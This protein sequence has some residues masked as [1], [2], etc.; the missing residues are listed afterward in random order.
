MATPELLEAADVLPDPGPAAHLLQGRVRYFHYGC[1]GFADHGWGCGYRSVQSILSWLLS[2]RPVETI[3]ALQR[4]LGLPEGTR[5]WIGVREAVVLLD[6]L[7]GAPVEILS[8]RSGSDVDAQLPRLA[9]HFD[10]G[11]GPVMIGGG[12]DVYSKTVV[13][14]CTGPEPALAI[15]D[16]HAT[17]PPL[18][19][20]A[21]RSLGSQLQTLWT[22]GWVAWKPVRTT[23]RADS[24][25]NIALP[26]RPAANSAAIETSAA[27]SSL[28]SLPPPTPPAPASAATNHPNKTD[29]ASLFDVVERG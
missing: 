26:R 12:G 22:E 6:V 11:G 16:P 19:K 17:A 1:D 21:Y 25:Y 13:G 4:V 18:S 2:E 8:L 27:M 20:A 7:C 14:V 3:P 28:S 24:F 23:F 15:L 5:S 29:W 9:R 10:E